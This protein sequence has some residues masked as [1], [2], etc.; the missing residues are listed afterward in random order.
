[1]GL[2]VMEIADIKLPVF[3]LE[4]AVFAGEVRT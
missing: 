4:N 2:I 3:S 1:M